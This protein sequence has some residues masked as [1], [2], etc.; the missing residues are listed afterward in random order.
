[1]IP[2][3]GNN[4]ALTHSR[5]NTPLPDQTPVPPNGAL[6]LNG[7]LPPPLPPTSGSAAFS[8]TPTV[9]ALVLALKRRWILACTLGVLGAI[10]AVMAVSVAFPPKYVAQA[11]LELASRPT[12]PIFDGTGGEPDTDPAIYRAS[13][14]AIIKSPLVLSNALNSDKLKG[15]KITGLSADSL[16]KAI[17]VDFLLGPEIMSVKLFGDDPEHL[18]DVLNAVTTAYKDEVENRDNQRKKVLIDQ[19]E[20]SLRE[21]QQKLAEKRKDLQVAEKDDNIADPQTLQMRINTATFKVTNIEAERRAVLNDL[22]KKK[23]DLADTKAQLAAVNTAPISHEKV[24]LLIYSLTQ[25]QSL[26]TKL[27]DVE[28][29]TSEWLPLPDSPQKT[30]ALDS[31]AEKKAS[32]LESV[33]KIEDKQ[34]PEI[35]KKLRAEMKETLEQDIRKLESNIGGLQNN[36]LTVTDALEKAQLELDA[37]TSNRRAGV[38]VENLRD[39]VKQI[40]KVQDTLHGRVALVKAEPAASKRIL[41]LQVAET[42]TDKDFSRLTKVGSAAGLG[43]FGLVL[44]G[45][46]FVEFRSRKVSGIDEVTQGLGLA[47]V[48]TMPKLPAGVQRP[49]QGAMTQQTIHWQSVIT[50]SVDAIRTQLLHASRTDAV[51][52]VMVT[53]PNGG[54]GKTSLASQLAASLARAWRKTLLVD[55]DLR[56]PAAH[57]L[58]NL[59]L[60]P[61]FS[62]LLRGEANIADVVK[63]TLLSRLWL[64]PAGHFDAHAIQALA[65]DNVAGIFDQMKEQYDFIIVDSCPVLPVADALLLGQH[66]DA[67]IFS[68]L[69]DVSR[70]PS[71]RTAQHKLQGLGVRMLGVV[72]IGTD[73]EP[74]SQD[75]KY[76]TQVTA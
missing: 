35:E 60:E 11:R 8:T 24:T 59:H 10:G 64:M 2:P 67:V 69:R 14:M 43:V 73:T 72:I 47:L 15:L 21:N 48:G 17:K 33:K 46:A 65:Q 61:G 34:R 12:K 23:L 44:F 31:L 58:F 13:A 51:H 68:V 57:K 7:A 53:S 50:E 37:L 54:E 38:R 75:Y 3:D 25:M 36:V 1:M 76:T 45:I 9:G 30:A 26:S 28:D 56:N 42:P 41:V 27:A 70:L 4:K 71:L 19:L 55:G 40:E 66:V 20:K 22:S 18:A 29:K 62:E 49:I 39:E 5:P 52:V 63:P 74:G 16:E 6:V 32:I